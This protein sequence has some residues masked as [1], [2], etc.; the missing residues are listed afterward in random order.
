MNIFHFPD[1]F[2]CRCRIAWCE[3]EFLQN[4]RANQ[5]CL[6]GPAR[7]AEPNT[8]PNLGR[9]KNPLP[10]LSIV[11]SHNSVIVRWH[12]TVL[13]FQL[14]ESTNVSLA[15]G[16]T[17]TAESRSTNKGSVS[18]TIPA[19]NS[20]KFFRLSSPCDWL[21]CE[22]LCREAEALLEPDQKPKTN[23]AR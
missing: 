21:H 23:F 11:R 15:N 2:A 7:I 22:I 10:T 1:R 8:R 12:V 17:S 6:L 5:H 20:H 9:D 19:T 18:V 4:R 13:N 3:H 16:W 14:Q